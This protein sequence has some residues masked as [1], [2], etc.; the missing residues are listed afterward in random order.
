M[1]CPTC[2]QQQVAENT[3]FCSSC[4]FPLTGISEV[5][6]N[7]GLLPNQANQIEFKSADS[8]RKRGIKKGAWLMLVGMLLV[9]PLISVFHLLTDTEPFLAAIATIISFFGGILRMIYALM[10]EDSNA[11]QLTPNNILPNANPQFLSAAQ[12]KILPPQQTLPVND[13][14]APQAGSWRDTNDFVNQP[15]VVDTT[16]KLL[17]K[18]D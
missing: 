14:V 2:G 17:Q 9:V 8:P 3:R 12:N 11:K 4:G 18:N 5:I 13:Y 7:N 10:F 1:F 15:S 6:Y 16:T